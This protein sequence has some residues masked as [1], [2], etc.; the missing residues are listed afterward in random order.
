VAVPA[1]ALVATRFDEAGLGWEAKNFQMVAVASRE[2][3][4]ASVPRI[5]WRSG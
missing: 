2:V 5:L 3:D 4:G 1:G